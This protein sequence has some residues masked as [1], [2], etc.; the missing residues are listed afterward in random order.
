MKKNIRRIAV[1]A[2]ALLLTQ[3]AIAAE[4]YV[5]DKEH[6]EIEFAWNHLG[7][8]TTSGNFKDFDGALT[9]DEANPSAS[10]VEVTIDIDSLDSNI[11]DL[12]EHLKGGDFF[13]VDQHPEAS[14][15][16]TAVRATGEDHY[17][18]DGELTLHGH[19]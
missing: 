3:P 13:E 2:A 4:R 19:T 5:F 18:V 11:P 8:S 14:F 9:F 15:E 12:D 1:A 16:S 7:F 10:S 6:T 17:E